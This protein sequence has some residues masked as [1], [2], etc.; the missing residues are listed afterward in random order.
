MTTK[1]H[2]VQPDLQ[3]WVS[4][5][6]G[7]TVVEVESSHVRMLSRPDVV[8]K[9][10]PRAATAI[11]ENMT[12]YSSIASHFRQTVVRRSVSFTN[13]HEFQLWSLLPVHGSAEGRI[14]TLL[15]DWLVVINIQIKSY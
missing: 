7:A 2:T 5:R 9:V 13:G 3:R 6:T 4:K 8:I 11:Q 10:I 1:D 15:F 12:T 14:C